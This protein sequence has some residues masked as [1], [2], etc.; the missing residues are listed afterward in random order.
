MM[1]EKTNCIANYKGECTVEKCQEE[2]TTTRDMKNL[3]KEQRKTL[4][5]ISRKSFDIYFKED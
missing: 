1:C 4:Y 3:D 5:N 2:I